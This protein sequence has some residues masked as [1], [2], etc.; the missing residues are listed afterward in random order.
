MVDEKPIYSTSLAAHI[1]FVRYVLFAV[2]AGLA[3]LAS[4]ELA[5]RF[6]PHQP[7]MMSILLGTGI[8]FFVKYALDKR[9]IF[10]DPYESHASELRKI[11]IYGASGVGTTL[12][13]WAMELGAWNIWNT[14]EAKYYGA[15]LGIALGNYIKY[16][17]D[18]RYAFG[19][20]G[21]LEKTAA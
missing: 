13:F 7:I 1:L 12:L 11:I 14:V 3:N 18:K 17:L 19:G 20:A 15:V 9:W 2:I 16:L 21:K 6:L 8:G 4:Q 5:V 10:L